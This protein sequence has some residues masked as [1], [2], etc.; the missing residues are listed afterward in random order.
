MEFVAGISFEEALDKLGERSPV[1]SILRSAEWSLVPVQLRERAFFSATI[2]SARWLQGR[3]DFLTDTL[4]NT[5]ALNEK[6]E[7]YFVAGGRAKFIEEARAEA[8]RNGLRSMTDPNEIG[9]LKDIQSATRLGL[10]YDVNIES[11]QNFG[12][13]KQGQDPDILE[14][15]PAQRFVRVKPV[16]KPRPLHQAHQNDVARKDNLKF[17]LAMNSRAI[18]G[19]GVVWPPYGFHSGMD[20]QDVGREESDRLGLTTPDEKVIADQS[21]E[22]RDQAPVPGSGIRRADIDFNANLQAS[23]HGLSDRLI[24][25]LRSAFGERVKIEGDTASWN[26]PKD[27]DPTE[28]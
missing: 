22:I 14:S 17:W 26:P 24:S 16:R 9:G 11:A 23:V 5:T 12:H 10:I 28:E 18:G 7:R 4:A 1:G 3:M 6:G 8:I 13:W 21:S 15:F 20:V 25:L 19:F 27:N 2:E